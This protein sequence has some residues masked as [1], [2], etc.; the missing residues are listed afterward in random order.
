MLLPGHLLKAGEQDQLVLDVGDEVA[1]LRQALLLP[2]VV[3]LW[4]VQNDVLDVKLA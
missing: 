1:G 3:A 2:G 4:A